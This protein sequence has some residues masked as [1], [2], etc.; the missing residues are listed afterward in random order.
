MTVLSTSPKSSSNSS[1]LQAPQKRYLETAGTLDSSSRTI[2]QLNDTIQLLKQQKEGLEQQLREVTVSDHLVPWVDLFWVIGK[3]NA[4]GAVRGECRVGSVLLSFGEGFF[5]SLSA[6]AWLLPKGHIQTI[7]SLTSENGQLK[8]AL[9]HTR[10][11][12]RH[13]EEESNK[14]VGCLQEALQQKGELER[15]LSAVSAQQDKA[16]RSSHC[17]EAVLERQLRNSRKELALLKAHMTQM[18]ASFHQVQLER[19]EYCQHIKGERSR[20]QQRM[21]KISEEV[22]TL[23]LEKRQDAHR[24]Q[25][26]E[27]S[28]AHLRNQLGKIPYMLL[29]FS[30]EAPRP[31]PPVGPSVA[32]QQL[33]FETNLLRINLETITEQLHAQVKNNENLNRLSSEQKTR[34]WQQEESLQE[35]RERMRLQEEELN[36]E[37]KNAVQLVQQIKELQEKLHNQKEHLEAATQEN[38]QPQDQLSLTTL[39]GEGHG[40]GHLDSEE[41]EV[42]RPSIA[43]ALESREAVGAFI[44]ATGAGAQEE[45]EQRVCYQHLAHPVASVQEPEAVTAASAPA[46]AP[47]S[48]TESE[49]LCGE[50]NHALQGA[51]EKL[52][53]GF[54]TLQK[55]KVDLKERVENLELL[56]IRLSGETDTMTTEG[57]PKAPAPG[58]GG[59]AG[60]EGKASS[61]SAGLRGMGVGMGMAAGTSVAA[62]HPC[63]QLQLQEPVFPILGDNEGHAKFLATAKNHVDGPAPGAPVPQGFGMVNKQRGE[64]S[65]QAGWAGRSRGDSPCAE[66]PTSLSPKIFPVALQDALLKLHDVLVP[67][68][69]AGEN[70]ASASSTFSGASQR[71]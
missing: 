43:E 50:T 19:D 38:Q 58:G 57:S 17:S 34:L 69:E 53:S 30:A 16:D 48:G 45:Q 40:G 11:A 27:R 10:R 29:P 65:H 51:I 20:W 60:D 68:L 23:K 2:G 46:S 15:T 24:L 59:K 14:L 13:F 67:P 18:K 36:N 66:I 64:W 9:Y 39:P 28:L 5:P 63:L 41:D 6:R 61:I 56:F 35:Q 31:E 3:E 4:K 55:E 47:A 32:E 49:S 1:S 52:Q 22:R 62:K 42:P 7:N 26:L 37:K 21:R 71:I 25:E 54:K 44:N 70:S 8:T 33:K 12:A